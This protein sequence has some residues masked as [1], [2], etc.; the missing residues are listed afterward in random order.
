VFVF[1][2]SNTEH[3]QEY[4]TLVGVDGI[5]GDNAP[6]LTRG[7]IGQRFHVADVTMIGFGRHYLTL[8]EVDI[9]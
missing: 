5:C 3:G 6:G 2:G 1:R 8:R 4:P 7:V 9:S